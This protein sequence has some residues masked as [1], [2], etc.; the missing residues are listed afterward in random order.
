MNQS[1]LISYPIAYVALVTLSRSEKCNMEEIGEVFEYLKNCED[2][3][4][5]VLTGNEKTFCIERDDGK[6]GMW[7]R[8]IRAV[9]RCNKL[10]IA[11]VSGYCIGAGVELL[12]A[13]GFRYCAKSA[14][15]SIR[16]QGN[17]I[18]SFDR[19]AN[20]VNN[21]SWVNELAYTGRNANATEA[22]TYGLFSQTFPDHLQVL[23]AALD[24]SKVLN[25]QSQIIP[26]KSIGNF[27]ANTLKN[28]LK[29][30]ESWKAYVSQSKTSKKT[31][32]FRVS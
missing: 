25:L 15:I 3:K 7:E 32:K 22:T 11:A 8:G 14:S 19:F 1:I 4:V 28:I 23:A 2:I 30:S 18:K 17:G 24:L 5:I 6:S 12:S 13:A 16:P 9:D 10:V 21:I 27:S 26:Y 29:Y 20:A 31:I